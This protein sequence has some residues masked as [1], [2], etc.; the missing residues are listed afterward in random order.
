[1]KATLRKSPEKRNSSY[2]ACIRGRL[3]HAKNTNHLRNTNIVF[4]GVS[5]R[6]GHIAK[7]K[8]TDVL[9]QM[10]VITLLMISA[11]QPDG[12]SWYGNFKT[13]T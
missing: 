13:E 12:G 2:I 6:R 4:V 5:L 8:M 7:V 1:M 3:S 11:S 9:F 10:V